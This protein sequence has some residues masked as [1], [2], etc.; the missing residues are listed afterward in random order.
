MN[1]SL[2]P[3]GG[4]GIFAAMD[5]SVLLPLGDQPE[6]NRACLESLARTLPSN[7]RGEVVLIADH[8]PENDAPP[9]KRCRVAPAESP[10]RPAAL[11]AAVRSVSAPILCFLDPDTVFLPGW[12]PPMLHVL[13]TAAHAGSV[14]NIQREPYSGLIDHAGIGFDARGL[15]VPAGRN[16]AL[17]PRDKS[18]R[19]AAV[20]MACCLVRRDAFERVGG[21][22]PGFHGP[23][24]EV[25]FCLRAA[26]AGWRH[27]VAN[28]SVV[29]RYNDAPSLSDDPDLPLHV[30]RWGRRALACHERR[31]RFRRES[32]GRSFSPERW[33]MAREARRLLRLEILDTRAHGWRYL[34]KH[35]LRPWRYNLGRVC[36]ALVQALAPPPAPL[37]PIPGAPAD[38]ARPD[39]GWLFDPPPQP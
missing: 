30:E 9:F 3:S 22:D 28:R 38:V 21:F 26:A 4:D 36:R 20:S 34:R 32:P 37:P 35:C 39:D 33:E 12:L 19:R 11:Q 14:G 8:F 15:P 2:P 27:Y 7:W 24:A 17:L 31:D 29:Y 13:Q 16:L 6:R 23:L 10:H 5:V 1:I 18:D 25:D